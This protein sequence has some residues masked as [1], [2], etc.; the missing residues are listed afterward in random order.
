MA[1]LTV[2]LES[3]QAVKLNVTVPTVV[4][5]IT[6]AHVGFD[7]AH[8]IISARKRLPADTAGKQLFCRTVGEL[9]ANKII[10][11]SKTSATIEATICFVGVGSVD[12]T[13]K[14][15]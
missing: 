4:L 7:M 15:G 5:L 12:V 8:L 14:V 10:F 2:G 9:V 13:F 3:E 11:R 1:F 6:G